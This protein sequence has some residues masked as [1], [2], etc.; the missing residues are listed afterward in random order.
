L[1]DF[2]I[3]ALRNNYHKSASTLDLQNLSEDFDIDVHKT[4]CSSVENAHKETL[5]GRNVLM[6][7]IQSSDQYAFIVSGLSPKQCAS[8]EN[9]PVIDAF[10]ILRLNLDFTKAEK[11]H[12]DRIT[13]PQLKSRVCRLFLRAKTTVALEKI[14]T[15]VMGVK[16]YFNNQEQTLIEKV[17]SQLLPPKQFPNSLAAFQN[18]IQKTLGSIEIINAKPSDRISSLSDLFHTEILLRYAME[19]GIKVTISRTETI[20]FGTIAGLPTINICSYNDMCCN[21]ENV[22]AEFMQQHP[23]QKMYVSSINAYIHPSRYAPYQF[24][25]NTSV[26]NIFKVAF[27]DQEDAKS[28]PSS[29]PTSPRTSSSSSTAP[30][31][32]ASSSDPIPLQSST[33]SPS[34]SD[35]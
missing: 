8:F 7:H 5:K 35:E 26:N 15:Y 3:A 11:G 25:I 29:P 10:D 21:C 18:Y 2:D 31:V 9:Y 22:L 6:F 20:D 24:S 28:P 23:R 14:K 19:S 32:R 4:M 1:A 34:S 27:T 17:Y 30:L 12:I 33:P 16:K 13:N